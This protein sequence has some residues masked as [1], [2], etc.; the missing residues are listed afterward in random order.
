MTQ[1]PGHVIALLGA[2]STGKTTLARELHRCLQEQGHHVALVEEALRVGG[3]MVHHHGV[4]K[5]RTP[6]VEAEH[7]SSWRLL[8]GLKEAFDPHGVMNPGTIY[9]LT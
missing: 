5:Y 9:P 1:P 2:E 8:T 3:S 7:G 6:W 4:G